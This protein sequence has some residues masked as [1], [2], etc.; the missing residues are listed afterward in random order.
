MLTSNSEI[1]NTKE[2][3]TVGV[4]GNDLAIAFNSK[5]FSDCLRVVD[6]AYVKMNFNSAIQPCVITP[7]ENDDFAFLILP[8]K[9]R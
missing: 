1:G 5:Y 7:C 3:I 8:V 6:N 2:N 4:K 9:S